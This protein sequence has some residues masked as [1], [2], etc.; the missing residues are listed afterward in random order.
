M[1]VKKDGFCLVT[2]MGQRGI[3]PQTFEFH[4]LMLYQRKILSPH[5]EHM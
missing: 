1:V 2:S 5:E 4:A 3:E